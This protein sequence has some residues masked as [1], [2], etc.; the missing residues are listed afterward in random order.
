MVLVEA[1]PNGTGAGR[2]GPARA[3][4]WQA[5]R[6]LAGSG[7]TDEQVPGCLVGPG[8]VGEVAPELVLPGDLASGRGITLHLGKSSGHG[9]RPASAA[10]CS[11]AMAE[12]IVMGQGVRRIFSDA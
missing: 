9:L 10:S 12:R 2:R 7:P 8:S 3:S 1:P 4:G 5:I 6:T 11:R